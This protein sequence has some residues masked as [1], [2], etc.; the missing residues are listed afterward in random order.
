[1]GVRNA[2]EKRN[3]VLGKRADKIHVLDNSDSMDPGDMAFEEDKVSVT[4]DDQL[5]ML[6]TIRGPELTPQAS[7]DSDA[8]TT[9]KEKRKDKKDKKG[10]TKDAT[11]IELQE[12][13]SD[14]PEFGG[15][16]SSSG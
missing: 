9:T 13:P 8:S 10:K 3:K 6:E 2:I 7:V 1:M 15:R 12:M 16:I 14:M 11:E 5:H 4:M